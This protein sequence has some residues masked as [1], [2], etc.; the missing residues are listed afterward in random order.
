[1]L[2]ILDV[3]LFFTLAVLFVE[4]VMQND[5]NEKDTLKV[6]G[7]LKAVSNAVIQGNLTV[8]GNVGFY[9]LINLTSD[10][11]EGYETP[12]TK[13]ITVEGLPENKE[14]PPTITPQNSMDADIAELE[15]E[16]WANIYYVGVEGETL[17]FYAYERPT[18]AL[19]LHV[20][21]V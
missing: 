4:I 21:V 9:K 10:G 13:T 20:S 1:M 8:N 17:T 7:L 19:Q 2:T 3:L 11:W 6:Y 18:Q 14:R 15:D 12:Y 16:A 5:K